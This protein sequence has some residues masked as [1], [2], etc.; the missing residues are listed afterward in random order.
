MTDKKQISNLLVIIILAGI[1]LTWVLPQKRLAFAATGDEGTMDCT[2]NPDDI[3]C[4]VDCTTNPDDP[5]CTPPSPSPSPEL[6]NSTPVAPQT[7]EGSATYNDPQ[8]RFSIDYPS[9]WTAKPAANRFD[10]DLVTLETGRH[11]PQFAQLT[12]GITKSSPLG[13]EQSLNALIPRLG[14]IIP[15]FELN[16]D[17]EC[18]K[19]MLDGIKACSFI[20]ARNLDYV[21]NI[22]IAAMQVSADIGENLYTLTYITLPDNFDRTLPTIEKMIASF[23]T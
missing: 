2:K 21:S 4:K 11:T 22:K 3:L 17:L 1:S 19:Y 13:I 5:L 12:V 9:N 10:K 14:E 8:G 15:K 23:K 6:T 16:Q 7:I 18:Q 20:Y